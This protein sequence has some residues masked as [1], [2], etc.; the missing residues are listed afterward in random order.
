[1]IKA[2]GRRVG[3]CPRITAA[4]E[5]TL[6]VSLALFCLMLGRTVCE[7][8]GSAECDCGSWEKCVSVGP[9]LTFPYSMT[10]L[11]FPARSTRSMKWVKI[12]SDFFRG[13]GER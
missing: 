3:V 2:R 4:F 7:V 12:L 5:R 8:G 6:V 11:L 13:G 1:M 9:S 10:G